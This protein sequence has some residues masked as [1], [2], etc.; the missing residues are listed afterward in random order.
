MNR[1]N[2]PFIAERI[3]FKRTQIGGKLKPAYDRN[4]IRIY[5][6]YL[7]RYFIRN[8]SSV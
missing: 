1:E 3:S 7:I 4:C 5:S 6:N 2:D 8:F